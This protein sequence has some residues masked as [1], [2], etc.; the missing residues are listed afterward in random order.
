M[1][2]NSI[3]KPKTNRYPSL[4]GTDPKFRRNHRYALHGTMRAL[5]SSPRP[6]HRPHPPRAW[7]DAECEADSHYRRRRRRASVRRFRRRNEPKAKPRL[8]FD[9]EGFGLR[10]TGHHTI[11]TVG[12]KLQGR[13]L[14][15]YHPGSEHHGQD[16]TA[17]VTA[18]IRRHQRHLCTAPRPPVLAL[19]R[20]TCSS[21]QAPA[22]G[23]TSNL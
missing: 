12:N 11:M 17:A 14:C 5:V 8:R 4:N 20:V 9:D 21:I 2:A 18:Q 16:A 7:W 15:L 22:A 23:L 19:S 10:Q 1:S 6:W 3:K 13:L